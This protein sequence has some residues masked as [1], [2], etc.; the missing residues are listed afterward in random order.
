MIEL[1]D[2][3]LEAFAADV[4]K[5]CCQKLLDSPCTPHEHVIEHML[6]FHGEF[7]AKYVKLINFSSTS[8][9]TWLRSNT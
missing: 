7:L 9:I 6:Y 1:D 8:H 2:L 3:T 4:P 5:E